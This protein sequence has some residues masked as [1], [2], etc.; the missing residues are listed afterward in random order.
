M[1]A[2]SKVIALNIV[3]PEGHSV[4]KAIFLAQHRALK[5]LYNEAMETLAQRL[6]I[7]MIPIP[8]VRD[9]GHWASQACPQYD[10]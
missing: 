8:K 2:H 9:G 3:A 10:V 7:D 1:R 4:I 5:D 6:M